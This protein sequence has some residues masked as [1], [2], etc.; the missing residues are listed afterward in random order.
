MGIYHGDARNITDRAG[1]CEDAHPRQRRISVVMEA[2]RETPAIRGNRDREDRMDYTELL[3]S[4]RSIRDFEA[5]DVS[6]ETIK[7]IIK[8]SCL[9]PSSG[10]RQE[11]RFII[12]NSREMLRRIS[13]ECKKNVLQEIED[14]PGT[15]MSRYKNVMENEGHNVFYNAPCLVLILGPKDNHT[16]EIDCT[17]IASYLMFSAVERGL[18]TC[19]I[20][21]GNYIQDRKMLDEIGV[22]GEYRLVAPIILGYPTRILDPAPRKDPQILKT[23]S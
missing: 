10:N 22:T 6:T 9:A 7:E 4:R 13:D 12:I 18:G 20:G 21:M 17:L 23:L 1:K 16:L 19:W 2:A 14:D 15:Y 11:W 8:E 3:K 5:K